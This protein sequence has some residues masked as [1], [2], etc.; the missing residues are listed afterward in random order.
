[1]I[2]GVTKSGFSYELQDNVMDNMELVD[3]LADDTTDITFRISKIIKLIFEPEQRKQLY[4][5]HRTEDGRV[6]VKEIYD[7]IS[8]IF[9]SFGAGKNS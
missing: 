9:S 1:M 6:P 4:A 3:L 5:K 2:K 8:E 7:E